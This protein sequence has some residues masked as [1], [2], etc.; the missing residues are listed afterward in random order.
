M[1]AL[2][3]QGQTA[4]VDRTMDAATQKIGKSLFNKLLALS[5]EY[6]RS[7][8][9]ETER[10]T[11]VPDLLRPLEAIKASQCIAEATSLYQKKVVRL[12]SQQGI[13][14]ESLLKGDK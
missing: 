9:Q 5:K 10:L 11:Q 6:E 2:K 3:R 12:F 13:S 7:I 8:Q 1:I 14:I 4:V